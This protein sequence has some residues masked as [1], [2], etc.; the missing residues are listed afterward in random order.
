MQPTSAPES[1]SKMSEETEL[2][3]EIGL[4]EKPLTPSD[5]GGCTC[6]R[7]DAEA[8]KHT[9]GSVPCRYHEG[10]AQQPW[11]H[12]IPWNCPTYWD[13]CNCEGGPYFY[14]AKA[15]PT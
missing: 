12:R 10:A 5:V 15:D 6:Q 1:G 11:N 4:P 7:F 8:G 9:Y 3:R 14:E 13:G 2:T